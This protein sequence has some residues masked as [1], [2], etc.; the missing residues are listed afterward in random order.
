MQRRVVT[1][2]LLLALTGIGPACANKPVSRERAMPPRGETECQLEGWAIDRD[3]QG[4]NVR[5]APSGDARILGKLPAFVVNDEEHDFG[6]P[7][8]IIGSRDGWL[9]INSAKDDPARSGIAARETYPGSG[10]ISGRMARFTVQSGQGYQRPDKSS[11]RIVDLG[12]DW[13]TDFG[14]LERVVACSGDWALVDFSVDKYRDPDTQALV[15]STG[16]KTQRAWFRGICANQE[17][18]CDG[19]EP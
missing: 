4:L 13:L 8:H 18:T 7:F 9:K 3:P 5:A 16:G 1:I 19:V 14:S 15:G 17:T 2:A 6:I 12:N 11:P 10:W